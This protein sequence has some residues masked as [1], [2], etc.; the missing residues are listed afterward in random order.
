MSHFVPIAGKVIEDE[1]GLL[2][3]L[4]TFSNVFSSSFLFSSFWFL[5]FFVFPLLLGLLST[6]HLLY[7]L[8]M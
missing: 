2:R 5:L 6:L 8:S 7:V 4:T 1:D 3:H